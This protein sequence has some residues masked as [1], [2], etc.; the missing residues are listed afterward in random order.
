MTQYVNLEWLIDKKDYE[1]A[2]AYASEHGIE[3]PCDMMK[4]LLDLA[5]GKDTVVGQHTH[6]TTP[7]Q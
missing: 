2:L 3:K 1:R 7:Q 5:I 4:H 6:S